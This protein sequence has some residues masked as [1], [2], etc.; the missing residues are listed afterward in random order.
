VRW[1]VP[2]GN[3]SQAWRTRCADATRRSGAE[4]EPRA[5]LRIRQAIAG[6]PRDLEFLRGQILARLDG[7]LAH[8]LARGL[9][10]VACALGESLHANRGELVVGGAE[11]G[12][13]VDPAMLAAQP[14]AEEQVRTR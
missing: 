1:T 12:T 2:G 7:S 5:D 4:E 3:G 8:F 11:L 9:K 6:K 14:L 13:R 10:L